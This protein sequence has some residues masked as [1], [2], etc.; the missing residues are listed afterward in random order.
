M[1]DNDAA[2]LSLPSR[3]EKPRDSGITHVLDKGIPLVTLA[4]LLDLAGAHMD[5]LKMGWGTSYVSGSVREKVE[6]CHRHSVR[7]STGGTM[8][9]IVAMQGKVSP[10]IKWAAGLGIDT[11]EV[12]DGA[13]GLHPQTRRQLI[14]ELAG[15][16]T[17]VSE[18]GSKMASAPVLPLEW[19]AHATSDLEAGASHV[20]A[21][22]RESG[23]VGLYEADGSVREELVEVMLDHLPAE[24][25]IFEAPHKAQQTWFVTRV[26]LDVN[27]G[28]VPPD[29]I[30]GVETLRRGLRADT[31]GMS[32]PTSRPSSPAAFEEDAEDAI[33]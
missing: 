9:E 12:S 11:V 5:I 29:E 10:F 2:F 6:A 15:E 13:L 30:L 23:T 24:R 31:A 4:S 1:K 28:N 25:I 22:G 18:V 26:G 21:E 7:V 19:V 14:K 33:G 17:V 16:F 8:L 3:P 20:I 32:L 27:L